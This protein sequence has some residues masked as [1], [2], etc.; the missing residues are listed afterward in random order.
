SPELDVLRPAQGVRSTGAGPCRRL[1]PS[2]RGSGA[3]G[4][5]PAGS[6]R[7]R[8]G[9]NPAGATP[10]DARCAPRRER[11]PGLAIALLARLGDTGFGL[12]CG[13]GHVE[14]HGDGDLG[15]IVQVVGEDDDPT[16]PALD[17]RAQS[18]PRAA[19]SLSRVAGARV[20]PA[21]GVRPGRSRRRAAP[22]RRPRPGPGSS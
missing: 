1:D 5:P 18:D 22:G 15:V 11:R 6:P 4:R 10:P 9:S 14:L 3:V 13:V 12:D 19:W 2:S 8:P 21:P 16:L 20:P 7:T 17:P